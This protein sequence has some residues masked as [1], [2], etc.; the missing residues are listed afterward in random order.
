MSSSILDLPKEQKEPYLIEIKHNQLN[1][2]IRFSGIVSSLFWLSPL[3][4]L[5]NRERFNES[6]NILY[7]KDTQ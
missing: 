3:G 1:Q 2:P 7:L 4:Y 6:W 5:F